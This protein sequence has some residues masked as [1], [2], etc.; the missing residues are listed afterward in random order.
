MSCIAEKSF[1]DQYV[2]NII[3]EHYIGLGYDIVFNS[4][5]VYSGSGRFRIS[6]S[7]APKKASE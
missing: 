1:C 2:S 3:A 4:D 5:N 7:W 6:L